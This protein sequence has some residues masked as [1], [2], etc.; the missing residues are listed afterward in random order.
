MPIPQAHRLLFEDL[1]AEL[2]AAP[3]FELVPAL[4]ATSSQRCW[5]FDGLFVND[6]LT[7]LGGRRGRSR[8]DW[9]PG[10][11]AHSPPA[12]AADT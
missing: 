6:H 7:G 4:V 12:D 11:V 10:L 3:P 8:G 1:R 5:D 9:A 2:P